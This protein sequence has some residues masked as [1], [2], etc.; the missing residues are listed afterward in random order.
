[1]SKKL[2]LK[3]KGFFCFFFV[4]LTLFQTVNISHHKQDWQLKFLD[5]WNAHQMHTKCIPNAYQL[6]VT[7]DIQ[8]KPTCLTIVLISLLAACKS[9][10]FVLF[11]KVARSCNEHKISQISFSWGSRQTTWYCFTGNFY[12]HPFASNILFYWQRFR[13]LKS[14][15]GLIKA[16]NWGKISIIVAIKNR[17]GFL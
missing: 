8:S 9:S 17:K 6:K 7:A 11:N 1:M 5:I 12:R 13:T 3:R 16:S 4:M 10:G 14:Q 15:S 2:F